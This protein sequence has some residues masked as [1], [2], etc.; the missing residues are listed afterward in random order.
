MICVND[1][2]IEDSVPSSLAIELIRRELQRRETQNK[3]YVLDGFPRSFAEA[4]GLF[5][6]RKRETNEEEIFG[7]L[8]SQKTKQLKHHYA[9]KKRLFFQRKAEALENSQ[10]NGE[11]TDNSNDLDRKG[12]SLNRNSSRTGNTSR[13][14]DTGKSQGQENVNPN[15]REG[16]LGTEG[17]Q[18]WGVLLEEGVLKKAA[19]VE[20]AEDEEEESGG[21]GMEE[22]EDLEE[23]TGE[24]K[25]FVDEEVEVETLRQELEAEYD[26]EEAHKR[27]Y[28]FQNSG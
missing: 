21:E 11:N 4:A 27:M 22:N 25:L 10:I 24:R 8:I 7:E 20:W 18:E 3:G 16:G 9:R 17:E 2:L 1:N 28:S 14:N 23:E 13:S 6:K 19:K 15:G 26:E 12:R 5:S